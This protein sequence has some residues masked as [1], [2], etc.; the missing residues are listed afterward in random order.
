MADEFSSLLGDAHHLLETTFARMVERLEKERD[1]SDQ[2]RRERDELVAEQSQAKKREDDLISK[3]TI[4]EERHT[5][6]ELLLAEERVDGQENNQKFLQARRGIKR[7][8]RKLEKL[9]QNNG[10]TIPQEW[11]KAR[12]LRE[13]GGQLDQMRN[14]MSQLTEKLR[15]EEMLSAQRATEMIG[16]AEELERVRKRCQED[17]VLSQQNLKEL[18]GHFD[19]ERRSLHGEVNK[20]R[21]ERQCIERTLARVKKQAES[22]CL[23]TYQCS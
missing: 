18:Q 23:M 22:I 19:A 10:V 2:L 8:K 5:E 17:E 4:Q 9:E 13:Q 15:A 11:H 12:L 6:L 1:Q 14:E 3:L 16:L 20:E 7:L 21:R